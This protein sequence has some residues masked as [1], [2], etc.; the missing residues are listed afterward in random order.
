MLSVLPMIPNIGIFINSKPSAKCNLIVEFQPDSIISICY[1]LYLIEI[2]Y[3]LFLF[4][5]VLTYLK[6]LSKT[7]GDGSLKTGTSSKVSV[8]R[9]RTALIILFYMICLI[10]RYTSSLQ[11]FSRAQKAEVSDTLLFLPS[12]LL[13][14]F[15]SLNLTLLT[16][17]MLSKH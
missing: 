5:S 14:Y 4:E 17:F 9:I 2:P 6:M 12:V 3:I 10:L 1:H 15:H 13:S 11:L 16:T 8:M 7:F